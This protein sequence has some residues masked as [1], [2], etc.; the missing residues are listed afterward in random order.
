MTSKDSGIH[1]EIPTLPQLPA[2][3]ETRM[4][5]IQNFTTKTTTNNIL[6]EN[7]NEI[8]DSTAAEETDPVE[9]IPCITDNDNEESAT[10]SC[11]TPPHSE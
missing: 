6:H 2:L 10:E 9:V 4:N 3:L 11:W 5:E 8:N 7:D 1:P